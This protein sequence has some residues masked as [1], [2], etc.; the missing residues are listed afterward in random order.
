[1]FSRI[2]VGWWWN[3]LVAYNVFDEMPQW[4]IWLIFDWFLFVRIRKSRPKEMSWLWAET[5]FAS[6]LTWNLN[7][8]IVFSPSSCIVVHCRF[9][10]SVTFRYCNSIWENIF[11]LSY[12]DQLRFTTLWSRGNW[13]RIDEEEKFIFI[14][15]LC[16]FVLLD[17]ILLRCGS[18][19]K[20]KIICGLKQ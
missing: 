9:N 16:W 8:F 13:S 12:A 5:F 14:F 6:L 18:E 17:A 4:S 10:A 7:P 1:M 11:F 19:G 3:I 2:C 15:M 20:G